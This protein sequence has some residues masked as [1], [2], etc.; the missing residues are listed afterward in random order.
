[1]GVPMIKCAICGSEVTKRSS[2]QVEPY[3]RICRS[4]PEVEQHKA[5]LAE[6]AQKQAEDK[7]L[8]EGLKSL[9]VMML[10]EHIRMMALTSGNSLNLTLMAFSYRLP[11][12]IRE[13]VVKQVMEKGPI[14]DEEQEKIVAMTAMMIAKGMVKL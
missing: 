12:D 11:K 3:G 7:K 9:N 1:M 5:K 4:H 8:Q 2:L 14:S 13:Q 10:V 6:I